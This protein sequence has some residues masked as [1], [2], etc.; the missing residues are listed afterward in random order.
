MEVEF[1]YILLEVETIFSHVSADKEGVVFVVSKR[2]ILSQNMMFSYPELSVIVPKPK[3]STGTAL[4]QEKTRTF[5]LN[6]RKVA[7]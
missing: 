4:W 2:G 6:K 7:S 5:Y 1:I 3:K